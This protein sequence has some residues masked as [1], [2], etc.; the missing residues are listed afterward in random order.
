MMARAMYKHKVMTGAGLCSAE[1]LDQMAIDGWE[2][3]QTPSRWA[4]AARATTALLRQR[5]PARR[6]CREGRKIRW[7]CARAGGS[8]SALEL[9][10]LVIAYCAAVWD[11]VGWLS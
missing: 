9:R 6:T 2:L 7:V 10:W 11:A 5:Q 4:T 1:I 8:M 3:I